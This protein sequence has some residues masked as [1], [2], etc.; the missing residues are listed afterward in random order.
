MKR[1]TKTHH[2]TD[3]YDILLNPDTIKALFENLK[4]N[5]S[6]EEILFN[7][8]VFARFLLGERKTLEFALRPVQVREVFE[9]DQVKNAILT[10]SF[11]ELNMNKSTLWHQKKRLNERGSI[12]LYNIGNNNGRV[13]NS[14]LLT[15]PPNTSRNPF[16]FQ[17]VSRNS[18]A[19]GVRT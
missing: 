5:L 10:K 3:E 6:L 19:L 17:K 13:Q 14:L 4:M 9:T 18:S 1:T 16:I 7:C 2:L 15:F 11:R 12:R 8:R